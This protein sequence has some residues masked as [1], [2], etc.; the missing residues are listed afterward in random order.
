M[1]KRRATATLILAGIA[2]LVL[3][4]AGCGP[5]E[6]VSPWELLTKRGSFIVGIGLPQVIL[7]IL[8]TITAA[9]LIYN[10]IRSLEGPKEEREWV[11]QPELDEEEGEEPAAVEAAAAAAAAAVAAAAQAAQA[12]PTAEPTTEPIFAPLKPAFTA[13]PPE[14]I[15]EAK[16]LEPAKAEGQAEAAPETPAEAAVTPEQVAREARSQEQVAPAAPTPEPQPQAPEPEPQPPAPELETPDATTFQPPPTVAP[17]EPTRFQEPPQISP[18][19]ESQGSDQ[20]PQ[21]T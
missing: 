2:S 17:S 21:E 4:S 7:G 16:P 13:P 3:A 15:G 20:G 6:G 10:V 11:K 1:A 9:A 18:P 14:V 5:R 19:D 8:I 12:A